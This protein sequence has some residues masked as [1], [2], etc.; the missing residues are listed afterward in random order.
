MSRWWLL[1]DWDIGTRWVMNQSCLGALM[2]HLQ[3]RQ[4]DHDCAGNSSG[5][6]A[7]ANKITTF[8]EVQPRSSLILRTRFRPGFGSRPLV[9]GRRY[10]EESARSRLASHTGAYPTTRMLRWRAARDPSNRSD[11][12]AAQRESTFADGHWRPAS[13]ALL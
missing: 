8:A 3:F 5:G 7:H 10:P 11:R 4:G 12:S 2:R 9:F 6:A 1:S 13:P